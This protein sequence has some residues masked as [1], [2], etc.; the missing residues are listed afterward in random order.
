MGDKVGDKA[1]DKVGDKNIDLFLGNTQ[2]RILAEIRNNP[3]V[4]KPH[5]AEI[6]NIGKTS[7]DKGIAQLKK[8]G[9]IERAV[10]INLVIG[11]C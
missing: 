8:H 10:L 4:T 2:I 7:V 11:K 9:Y 6:L 3:H 5:L 1:G